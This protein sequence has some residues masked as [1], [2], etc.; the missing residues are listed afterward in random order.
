MPKITGSGKIR[1]KATRFVVPADVSGG[2]CRRGLHLC[3]QVPL[4]VYLHRPD[5]RQAKAKSKL[6]T[7]KIKSTFGNS[8]MVAII[9]PAGDYEKEGKILEDPVPG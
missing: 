3:Q 9:V 7:Q 4:C 5:H 6:P 2:G 1:R 8:N